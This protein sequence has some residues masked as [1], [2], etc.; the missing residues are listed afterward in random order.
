M[1]NLHTL[2]ELINSV[3]VPLCHP[4]PVPKL[5]RNTMQEEQHLSRTF[6]LETSLLLHKALHLC[7]MLKGIA[8]DAPTGSKLKHHIKHN[9]TTA[10]LK[11]RAR[12]LHQIRDE[13]R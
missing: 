10:D 9:V 2:N 12:Q 13:F 6:L 3:D 4:S 5:V 7:V 11:A 1:P 8:A